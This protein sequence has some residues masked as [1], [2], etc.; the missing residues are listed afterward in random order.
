[1]TIKEVMHKP[2]FVEE[3]ITVENVSKLMSKKN[4]GS[5][6]VGTNKKALGI[7]SERDILRKIISHG[8]NPKTAQIK[9][10]M[11]AQIY[12]INVNKRLIDALNIMT[13][14][15]IRRLPV[16]KDGIIIGMLSSRRLS[17]NMKYSYLR[18]RAIPKFR[19]KFSSFW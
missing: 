10:Y 17:Q 8:I 11:T 4:I 16:E 2:T 19:E 14:K 18:S 7:F 15:H 13:E 1:M 5:V 9:N 12:V 6:I 3:T